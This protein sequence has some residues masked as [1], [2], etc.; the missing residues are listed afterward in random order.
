MCTALRRAGVNVEGAVY[1]TTSYLSGLILHVTWME[2]QVPGAVMDLS[3]ICQDP[4][5]S[6]FSVQ[7]SQ[8][9]NTVP[10]A[11][12]VPRLRK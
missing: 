1:D 8:G 4:V 3:V 2:T 7:R 12:Q 10:D 11:A 6:S 5:E 9:Q